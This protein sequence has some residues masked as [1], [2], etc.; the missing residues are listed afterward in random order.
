MKKD[1]TH[2]I[3]LLALSGALGSTALYAGGMGPIVPIHNWTGF[4]LGANAGVQWASFSGVTSVDT[5]I[6]DASTIIGPSTQFYNAD[7]TSFT[8][9]G[10]IGY[11]YQTIS[12]WIIGAEFNFNGEHLDRVHYLTAAEI[13]PGSIFVAGNSYS[14]TNDWHS[15]VLGRFGYAWNNWMVYATG[16]VSLAN[17]Q[18]SL[19]FVERDINGDIFP[20]TS[21]SSNRVLVGGTAGVGL[22]YA[23][24]PY[25]QIGVEGRYFDY[26][27]QSYNLAPIP[28]YTEGG[29]QFLFSPSFARIDTRSEDVIVK[30]NYQFT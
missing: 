27:T 11:N 16:G 5:L 3:F 25:L 23:L 17:Q 6:V 29:G 7:L 2:K 10:Q 8:G 24:A 9:G 13:T 4:Y 12:N 26:G 20:Q 21:G 14:A 19:N 15:S 28:V 18:F 30:I 22:S 1:F